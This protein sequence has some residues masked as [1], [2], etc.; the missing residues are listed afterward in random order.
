MKKSI[1]KNHLLS[2]N[3]MIATLPQSKTTSIMIYVISHQN[4]Y[5]KLPPKTDINT[6]IKKKRQDQNKRVSEC[7]LKRPIK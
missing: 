5:R 6:F 2:L 1:S 7:S 3:K 4:N